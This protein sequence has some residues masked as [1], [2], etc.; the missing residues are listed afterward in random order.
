M[1][2]SLQT[3]R[4]YSRLHMAVLIGGFFF[5][6][7]SRVTAQDANGAETIETIDSLKGVQERFTNA[8]DAYANI[9]SLQSAQPEASWQG[10]FWLNNPGIWIL[11]AVLIGL[12]MLL[13]AMR[14]S[15]LESHALSLSEPRVRAI[16][17]DRAQISAV[18]TAF[19]QPLVQPVKVVKIKVRKLK[20]QTKR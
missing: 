6:R 12:L 4:T 5:F 18:P 7:A 14:R 16:E 15:I 11:V 1:H 8:Q 9:V 3:K 20:K 19:Q 10:I 13:F 2:E 17:P